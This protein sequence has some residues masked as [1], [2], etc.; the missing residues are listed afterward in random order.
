[1]GDAPPHGRTGRFQQKLINSSL[2]KQKEEP[3]GNGKGGKRDVETPRRSRNGK[4][5]KGKKVR[6]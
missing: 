5:E 3:G 1:M 4:E 6:P 2:E